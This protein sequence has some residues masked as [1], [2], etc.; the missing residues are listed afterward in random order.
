M[1][2]LAEWTYCPRC[3]TELERGPGSVKCPACGFREYASSVPTSSALVVDDVGRVLLAR[4][5]R[6]PEVGKWDLP[7][8]FLDEGEHFLRVRLP[9]YL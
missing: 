4:R 3:R 1:A 5:A 8:G 6:E 2:A 7:G 9:N